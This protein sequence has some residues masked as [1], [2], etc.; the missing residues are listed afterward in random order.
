MGT[1]A[2]NIPQLPKV[3]EKDGFIIRNGRP[4]DCA[5]I[6]RYIKDLAVYEKEPESVVEVTEEVLRK[7]GFGDSPTFRCLV[8]EKQNEGQRIIVGYAIYVNS[9]STW[10]GRS[11]WIEDL[12]VRPDSRGQGIGL[13]FLKCLSK[14]SLDNGLAKIRC[15][16]LC[17]NDI[18]ISF[19]DKIGGI[20]EDEW[21]QCTFTHEVMKQLVKSQ[22]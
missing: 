22:P 12:F 1:A 3:V 19:Y 16:V 10:K 9:Y 14:I 20:V 13:E 7:D 21:R 6:V 17:W 8:A 2:E 15:N 5:A 18:A 4:D 11:L